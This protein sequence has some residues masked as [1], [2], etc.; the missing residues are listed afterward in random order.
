M[1]RHIQEYTGDNN[2]SCYATCIA[3]I[4]EI[5]LDRIPNFV[6][7][8]NC[9]VVEADKWIREHH[10]MR[11]IRIE[12]YNKNNSRMIGRNAIFNRLCDPEQLV[13]LS[14]KSPR[15]TEDGKVKYHAVVGRPD[16][17]GFEIVHDPHPSG[18]GL[19]GFPYAIDWIVKI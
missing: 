1:I 8:E 7:S 18:K 19:D 2:G 11:L 13:I 14:G 6:L 3:S 9:M 10:N 15:R 4:L 17:W 16:N 12:L 5:P